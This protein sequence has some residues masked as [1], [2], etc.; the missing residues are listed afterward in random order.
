MGEDAD[1]DRRGD[2]T[3]VARSD[4][5]YYCPDAGTVERCVE[6]IRESDERLRRRP[7]EM[8]LW[9]WQSTYFEADPDNEHG[10]GMILLGVAWYD[11]EFYTERRDAGFGYMH[12]RIYAKIGVPL[13]NVEVVHWC[14]DQ[15]AA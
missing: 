14:L 12:K 2:K 9:D 13:E 4:C 15:T 8:M 6:A 1:T 10:G 11:S 7:E 5:R 3:P